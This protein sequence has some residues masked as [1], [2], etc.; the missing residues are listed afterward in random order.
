MCFKSFEF[1]VVY[2]PKCSVFSW[3]A[4]LYKTKMTLDFV[5]DKEIVKMSESG[6]R[7]GVS[8]AAKT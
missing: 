5:R 7:G 4:F 3:Q 8:M 1:E 2:V 6:A